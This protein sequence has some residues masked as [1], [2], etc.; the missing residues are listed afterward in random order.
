MSA[1]RFPIRVRRGSCVVSIYPTPTHGCPSYTLAYY[2]SDQKRHRRTFSDLTTAKAAAEQTVAALAAGKQEILVLS[3]TPL[4]VYQRALAAV[5]TIGGQLDEAATRYVQASRMLGDISV[6][7]A[8]RAY[9]ARKEPEIKSRTVFEVAQ[10]LLA[11]KREKGRSA[12]YLKDLRLRLDRISKAFPGP[13][14]DVT[15]QD[16]ELFLGEL[17]LG[18]RSR[19]N[20]RLVFGT[21][22]K[23]G[24]RRGYVHKD[25]SGIADIERASHPGDEVVVFTPEEMRKL[26]SCAPPNLVP[27]LALCGFAGIRPE[28]VKRLTW[29]GVALEHHHIEIRAAMAKTRV[30]RLI[31]IQP[32]LHAW[33][34]PHRKASG[35]V[36]NYVNLGNR[37]LK[38]AK[39][40]GVAWKRN[41]LRHSFISYRVAQ[42]RDIQA[43]SIEA[44][45]SPTILTRNYL[46]CVTESAAKEWF[47]IVPEN[48]A[49]GVS[50]NVPRT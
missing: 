28:E 10:E 6:L 8:V 37:F 38:L 40:A 16:V 15:P 39:Q 33:L 31:P 14:G 23:F 29:D 47:S 2:D 42:T 9:K 22:L 48:L 34:M 13:L 41:G 36:Q 50:T 3:G 19:N 43:V 4:L 17:S 27:A 11:V 1:A 18:P 49:S 25:H 7:D 35:P 20:F 12:V 46:K 5:G 32:N 44:G 24:Q 30:R 26:L 45:N 21:L